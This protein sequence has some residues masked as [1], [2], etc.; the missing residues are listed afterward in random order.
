MNLPVFNISVAICCLLQLNKTCYLKL[1]A[2][3]ISLGHGKS[4]SLLLY[5]NPALID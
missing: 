3:D 1:F 2:L 5:V 4:M